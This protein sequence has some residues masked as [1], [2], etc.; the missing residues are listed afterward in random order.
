MWVAPGVY[1][2]AQ[3][4][5]LSFLQKA[6]TVKS[7][8]G[9]PYDTVIDLQQLG[10]TIFRS[11]GWQTSSDTLITRK[12][13]SLSFR[14]NKFMCAWRISYYKWVWS[15]VCWSNKVIKYLHTY[16]ISTCQHV[17]SNWCLLLFEIVSLLAIQQESWVVLYC[18]CYSYY[19]YHLSITHGYQ[20]ITPHI[21][22]S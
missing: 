20:F 15:T 10:E 12:S 18:M 14:G 3:N 8:S 2:G 1:R 5:N 11:I 22:P 7:S 21:L 19:S 16:C 6:I 4:R 13:I 9:N 17:V